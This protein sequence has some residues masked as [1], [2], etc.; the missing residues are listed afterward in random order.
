MLKFYWFS[1]KKNVRTNS[2]DCKN[3]QS[4]SC[5]SQ[6][7]VAAWSKDEKGG[8]EVTRSLAENILLQSYNQILSGA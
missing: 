6:H 1:N 4:I 5:F 2:L 8:K 3:I 7:V